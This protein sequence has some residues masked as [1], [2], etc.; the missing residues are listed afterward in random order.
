MQQMWKNDHM[1]VSRARASTAGESP[2][3][4]L[5]II[6]QLEIP[7]LTVGD[8]IIMGKIKKDGNRKVH[9]YHAHSCL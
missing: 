4:S 8:I 1:Q 3:V 6:I 7:K 9:L 5:R 2:I